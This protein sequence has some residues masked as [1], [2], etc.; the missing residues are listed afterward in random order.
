[1]NVKEVAGN[2]VTGTLAHYVETAIPLT[3]VTIWIIVALQATWL[4]DQP[5]SMWIRLAWPALLVQQQYQRWKSRWS[6][7]QPVS[8][9]SRSEDFDLKDTKSHW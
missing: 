7:P 2:S 8:F 1:M 3:I 9:S 6:H 5:R 4:N